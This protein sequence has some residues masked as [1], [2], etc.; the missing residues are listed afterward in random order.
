MLPQPASS[1][2]IAA[3]ATTRAHIPR[4]EDGLTLRAATSERE[5]D[6]DILS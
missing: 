1:P 5:K 3:P 6:A 2:S 4:T